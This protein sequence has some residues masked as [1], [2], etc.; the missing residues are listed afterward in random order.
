MVEAIKRVPGTVQLLATQLKV[1]LPSGFESLFAVSLK[2][3]E[4]DLAGVAASK[5]FVSRCEVLWK[6]PEVSAWL[7]SGL[8]RVVLQQE[9]GVLPTIS[10]SAAPMSA[11]VAIY[12]HA[13]LSD[14]PALKVSFPP[15]LSSQLNSFDPCP[16]EYYESDAVG[17]ILGRLR[18]LFF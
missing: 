6:D 17:G 9:G 7:R 16:P 3:F 15:S 14:L 12:R 4:G 5:I 10:V 18:Q 8:N 1:S 13:L 2:D 11:Q